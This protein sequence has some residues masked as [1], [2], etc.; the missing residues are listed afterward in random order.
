MIILKPTDLYAEIVWL[1]KVGDRA[2][3]LTSEPTERVSMTF[4]GIEGEAHSGLTRPACT[5]TK[6]QHAIGTEIRNTRQISIVSEEDMAELAVRME[7]PEIKPE[8]VGAN[9]ML[10]G[11]PSLTYLPSSS[12]LI[13]E[14]G[15]SLV[16]DMENSPCRHPG[17]F[18]E[19]IYPGKGRNFPRHAVGL[20]GVVCWVERPGALALSGHLRLHVPPQRIY[21]PAASR[22]KTAN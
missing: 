2:T 22:P 11:L 19:K 15:P 20:R 6:L 16:V 5:R 14:T 13:S 10:R 7:V 4:A 21:S 8:W 9:I 17:D 1:G 3:G 18:L 12:R